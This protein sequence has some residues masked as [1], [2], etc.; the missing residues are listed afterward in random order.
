[1]T[2]GVRKLLQEGKCDMVKENINKVICE[3]EEI[4]MLNIRNRNGGSGNCQGARE[5][6]DRRQQKQEKINKNL[7]EKEKLGG[8]VNC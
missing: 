7:R 1:M 4:K 5:P 8:Q 2:E 3:Q 6:T